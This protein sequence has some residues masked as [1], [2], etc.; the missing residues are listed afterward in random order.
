MRELSQILGFVGTVIVALGYL[1]Q[2]W[3]LAREHCSAGISVSAWWI[4]L[5]S[6]VLIA[7]HA[8][9]VFDLV[10]IAL[11]T[12]NMVAI[13][14]TIYL[15]RRYEGMTCAFHRLVA[16]QTAGAASTGGETP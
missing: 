11:Q 9:G 15:A 2:I 16:N 10:L 3:H 8:F 5:V 14:L 13:A 6:S 1:P 4:W 12:V 7:T